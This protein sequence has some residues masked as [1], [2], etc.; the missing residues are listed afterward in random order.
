MPM[1]ATL[2]DLTAMRILTPTAGSAAGSRTSSCGA[3]RIP[4]YWT[5]ARDANQ[6]VT[7]YRLAGDGYEILATTPLAWVLNSSPDD[8]LD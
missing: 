5:V 6:A 8:H 1:V 3:S 4:R 7:M 2:D